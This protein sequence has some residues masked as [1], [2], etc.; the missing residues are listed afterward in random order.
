MGEVRETPSPEPSKIAYKRMPFGESW[1]MGAI[2]V[3]PVAGQG[4]HRNPQES[5]EFPEI[6]QEYR[7]I[8]G[9]VQKTPKRMNSRETH[10]PGHAKALVKRVYF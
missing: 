6:H 9:M 7:E 10:A 8:T 4:I 5:E 3:Q 2:L 1:G